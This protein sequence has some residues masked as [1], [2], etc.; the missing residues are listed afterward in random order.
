MDI[1]CLG[2]K[3]NL[4]SNFYH[5]GNVQKLGAGEEGRGDDGSV[6][7]NRNAWLAGHLPGFGCTS[8]IKLER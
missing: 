4:R 1:S 6:C 8:I 2:E 5:P 3:R 7:L